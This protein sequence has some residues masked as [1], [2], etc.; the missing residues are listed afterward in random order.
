[1]SILGRDL[2]YED[3][4]FKAFNGILNAYRTSKTVTGYL[5]HF[6]GIPIL[7]LEDDYASGTATFL[8]GLLWD[9]A[10]HA[11][12]REIPDW[13]MAIVELGI[14]HWA[15]LVFMRRGSALQMP[16]RPGC[17]LEYA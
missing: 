10:T 5:D 15:D 17:N 3:D 1:M 16:G 11:N 8:Q 4:I 6:W 13:P 12:G 9:T 14:T 7:K 2:S